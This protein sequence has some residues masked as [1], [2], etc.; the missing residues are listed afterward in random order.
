M[1]YHALQQKLFELDPTDP[2]E[3]LAKLTA[4]AQ[5]GAVADVAVAK[6]Y[7]TESVEV[8]PGTLDVGTNSLSDFAALAGVKT[9]TTRSVTE[10]VA[11]KLEVGYAE[12]LDNKDARI[13]MLEERVARLEEMLEA[14]MKMPKQP[15]PVA[16]NMNK[17]NKASVVPNKK[18]DDKQGYEKH[19]SKEY[20]SSNIKD[21]LFAELAKYELKK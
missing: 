9:S 19:K 16:K 1:D 17:F 4:Q 3:D 5:G 15:N 2:R 6:D 18:K 7:V 8:R 20:E 10:T 13:A 11:P 21:R 14:Q 12:T